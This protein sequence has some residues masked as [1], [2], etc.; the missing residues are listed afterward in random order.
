MGRVEGEEDV[1]QDEVVT[2]GRHGVVRVAAEDGVEAGGDEHC[3]PRVQAV[4]EQFPQRT[5]CLRAPRL[6]PVYTV[7]TWREHENILFGA[8]TTTLV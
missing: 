8:K 7:C 4:V 5:T 3:S 1:P 2:D 6:L